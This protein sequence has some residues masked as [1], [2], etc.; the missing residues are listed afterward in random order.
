[1]CNVFLMRNSELSEGIA[2]M[3]HDRNVVGTSKIAAK[4]VRDIIHICL[5]RNGFCSYVPFISCMLFCIGNSQ[6]RIAQCNRTNHI[7][8][9]RHFDFFVIFQRK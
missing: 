8:S 2:V 7:Y 1:M 3:D 5:E 9:R 6:I 4:K